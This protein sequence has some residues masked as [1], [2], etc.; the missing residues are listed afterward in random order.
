MNAV[1]PA[2][3]FG[4]DETLCG[5]AAGGDRFAEEALVVRH[6]RLVRICAR[7]FFLA[8]G[9]SEDLIQEGM[10][11][12]LAAIREFDPCKNVSFSTFAATCIRNRIVSAIKAASRD[13]HTPLNT[14]ISLETPFFDRKTDQHFAGRSDPGQEN[15]EDIILRQEHLRE[16]L[17]R[18]K[19]QL[20]G[21][22]AQILDL[23]LSGLSYHEIAHEVNRSS[24]SVDNAVQRIQRKVAQRISSGESSES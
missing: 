5:L 2:G 14:Y 9:D 8:G 11:G 10:V 17:D 18:L 12:L 15:P 13:K 22:E 6:T 4:T 20:S 19:S 23:Y 21:F 3:E 24:K 7:P 16:G 1:T